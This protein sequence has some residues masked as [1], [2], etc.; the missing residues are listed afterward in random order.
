MALSLSSLCAVIR[1]HGLL[2]CIAYGLH[3]DVFLQQSTHIQALIPVIPSLCLSCELLL[4]RI[5]FPPCVT[6]QSSASRLEQKQV[7][8]KVAHINLCIVRPMERF[9]PPICSLSLPNESVCLSGLSTL[10]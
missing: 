7:S 5:F 6:V 8:F 3:L 4:C 1:H 2:G 9:Q 10:S